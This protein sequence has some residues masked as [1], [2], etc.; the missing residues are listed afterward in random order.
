MSRQL[1]E[2]ARHKGAVLG[3]TAFTILAV[4]L[5]LTVAGTLSRAQSGDAISVTAVF[6]DATGLRPGDEVRVAGVRVGRVTETR[7][8][9]GDEAG[10]A[11]VTMTIDADQELHADVIASVDYLNLMGQRFIS[12]ARPEQPTTDAALADGDRIPLSQ[13]RPALDLTAMFNAFRPIFD[14]LQPAD[15]NQLATN[16]VQVLQGQ[17]P[18]LEHLLTQTAELTSGLVDRDQVLSEVVDNVT[19]V[20]DTAHRHRA[21]VTRLVDGLDSL[22]S[23]LSRDR[24]RIA[25][26]LD[27]VAR[28]TETTADLV[29]DAGPDLVE[30]VRLSDPWLGYLA[31]R[32]NLL[33]D[34]GAAVPKQLDVY[35]RTLGY[36][37]YLNTYICTHHMKMKGHDATFDLGVLGDRFSSRCRT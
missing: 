25:T 9:T 20:L 3:V 33:V 21:D 23:G 12:L 11:V 26:S 34:T 1:S 22:M 10:T 14:L 7:V 16:V 31:A 29:G 24:R 18:T 15:L 2:L 28:L 19:L 36:G 5:T 35:L 37:S 32:E 4:A 6:R 30:V 13:T 27:S 17:G 8:G